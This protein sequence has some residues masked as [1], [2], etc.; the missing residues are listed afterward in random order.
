ML[1]HSLSPLL[2]TPC[3]GSTVAV[4]TVHLGAAFPGTQD[5]L[6]SAVALELTWGPCSLLL[7]TS[8]VVKFCQSSKGSSL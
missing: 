5:V 7:C 6:G 8:G 4:K 2:H 1:K 3:H